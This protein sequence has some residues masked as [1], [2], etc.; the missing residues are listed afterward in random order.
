MA[1]WP[2]NL[3]NYAEASSSIVGVDTTQNAI[4]LNSTSANSAQM[5]QDSAI[6]STYFQFGF[7]SVAEYRGAP[8]LGSNTF[9]CLEFGSAATV[10]AYGNNGTVTKQ[11]GLIG[12]TWQ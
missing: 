2:V 12:Q 7:Y 8:P 10:T 11:L 3:R 1:G 5:I 6:S 4:G 9:N